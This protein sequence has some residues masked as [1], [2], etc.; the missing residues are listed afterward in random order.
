MKSERTKRLQ[1]TLGN[2][3]MV[4]EGGGCILAQLPAPTRRPEHLKLNPQS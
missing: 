3:G 4:V 1:E 2:A